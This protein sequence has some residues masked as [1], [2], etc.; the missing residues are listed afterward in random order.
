[1]KMK[2]SV[3]LTMLLCFSTALLA[4]EEMPK[5]T[6]K[7][8]GF[9]EL[10][11]TDFLFNYYVDSVSQLCYIT[12]YNQRGPIAVTVIPCRNLKKRPEWSKIIV[13]E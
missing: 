6:Q 3:L 2:K 13:W 1:M 10:P 8:N 9:Y 12:P 7:P 4:T 11:G 5:V